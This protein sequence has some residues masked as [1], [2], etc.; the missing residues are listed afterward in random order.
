MESSPAYRFFMEDF[1]QCIANYVT[2]NVL[3]P[4]HARTTYFLVLEGVHT[5]M[6]CARN[7]V[8]VKRAWRTC[9]QT[10]ESPEVVFVF[11]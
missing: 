4:L 10:R 3:G 11:G 9:N 8:S 6:M 7:K 2:K 5:G 1:N